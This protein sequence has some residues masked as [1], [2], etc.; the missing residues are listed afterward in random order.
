RAGA[1]P[2]LADKQ[3]NSPLHA[4]VWRGHART[5]TLLLKYGADPS[6]KSASGATPLEDARSRGRKDLVAALEA[7]PARPVAANRLDSPVVLRRPD[8]V[9]GSAR[10]RAAG[11][12]Q[13]LVYTADGKQLVAGDRGGAIRF[14]DSRTGELRNVINA[15]DGAVLGLA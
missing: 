3:G 10:F 11:G 1:D 14:F 12:G 15:H 9:F 4:A 6:R 5:V 13:A 7:K 2:N 8:A